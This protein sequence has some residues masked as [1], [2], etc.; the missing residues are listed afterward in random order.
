MTTRITHHLPNG[1][2]IFIEEKHDTPIVSHWTWYRVGS[3]NE[4]PGITGISHWV[5]HMQFKGTPSQPKGSIFGAVSRVGGY[6]NA[7]TSSDWT[8][9]YETIPAAEIDLPIRIEADRMRNSRYDPA[10]VD[11]ERTVILSERQ[12]SEN[13][14]IY[15]LHEEFIATAFPGHAYGHAIIGREQDLRSMSRD[16]LYGHY[17]RYYRPTNAFLTIV[18]DVDADTLIPRLTEAFG[19]ITDDGVV[20]PPV[21]PGPEQFA[22]RRITLRRP[23]PAAYL[24]LGYK[25]PG[26]NHADTA[27]LMVADAILSGAKTMG[28]GGGGGMGRSRRLYKALVSSNLARSAGSSASPDLDESLWSFHA[29]ALP[30]VDPARIEEAINAEIARLQETLPEEEEFTTARKQ[31]RAQYAYGNQTV[32]S[33]A[34]WLGNMEILDHIGRVDTFPDE[35]A[36]VTP[37]DVQRVAR[38][39]L[40]PEHKTIAWQLPT[41]G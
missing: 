41:E 24:M 9:Y 8:T 10:E 19:P 13:S 26:A 34:F 22:E 31:L 39:Y 38:T 40:V 15:R 3:R 14:P 25:I 5:E 17:Q 2:T 1:L 37:D 36:A 16:D 18:G 23:S 20:I 7:M 12:G 27:A 29:T 32:T 35:F 33:R 30:G 4:R 11:A 6:L 28:L 21:S